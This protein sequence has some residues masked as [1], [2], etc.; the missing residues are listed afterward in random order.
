M[1]SSGDHKVRANAILKSL[2]ER[3]SDR[4]KDKAYSNSNSKGAKNFFVK[5]EEFI[6]EQTRVFMAQATINKKIEQKNQE[7]KI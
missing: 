6:K 1:A 3:F 5:E 4:L 7:N 2:L